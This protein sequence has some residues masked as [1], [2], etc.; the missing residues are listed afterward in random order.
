MTDEIV[1]GLMDSLK[2]HLQTKLVD[3]VPAAY[4]A[5]LAYTDK[6]GTA[7]VLMPSLIKIGVFQD[8]PTTLPDDAA[9]PSTHISINSGDPDDMS[10]GWIHG[11]ASSISS[12]VSNLHQQVPVYEIGGGNRWW[13]RFKVQFQAYFIYSDQGQTESNRL[14][15]LYR[16]MIE[17]CAESYSNA[18]PHGW[19]I[20]GT[21]FAFGEI[22]L[23]SQVAKSYVIE[24]G[25]PPDD[26]NWEGEVWIQVLTSRE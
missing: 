1:Y 11:L 18:N 6:N 16:V 24:G 4:Q 8:D 9:I 10:D 12:S 3:T 15:N 2:D 20:G 17:R 21:Q 25:G 23:K 13:R 26:F 14:A 7:R 22:A 5:D 19:Q